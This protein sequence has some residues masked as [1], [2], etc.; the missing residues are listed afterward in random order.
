MRYNDSRDGTDKVDKVLEKYKAAWD[1]KGMVSSNGMYVDFWMVKQDHVM[2]PTDVGWTAWAGAFMNTWNPQLVESLYPKQAHGFITNISGRIRLQPP[3]VANIFRRLTTESPNTSDQDKLAQAVSLAREQLAAPAANKPAF[4]FTKPIFGYVVE[5]LSEL[6]RAEEL[7]GL[8][9]Y[10]DDHL[11]PTWENG[12]LYYPRNDT[13]FIFA[14]D[15][16]DEAGDGVQWT[17]VDPFSGNAAIGYGRLNVPSGQRKMYESPWT[18]ESL[19][20]TPWI[21]NLHFVDPLHGVSVLRGLWDEEANALVLTLKGWDFVGSTACPASVD[22]EPVARGLT[23]GKWAVYVDGEL[24][25][26][27]HLDGKDGEGFGWNVSVKKGQE[28]DVVFLSVQGEE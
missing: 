25:E 18:R 28:V 19:R 4:P 21:D 11:H 2:P 13:P 26:V 22:V 10:A 5:W 8:L 6:G 27:K 9:A 15:S 14:D 12:G 20:T 17:H 24:A 1:Q 3:V 23:Q 7:E 16:D